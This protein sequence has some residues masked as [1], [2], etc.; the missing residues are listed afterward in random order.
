MDERLAGQ[1]MLALYRCGRQADA[2][3]HFQQMRS[4]MVDELGIDPGPALKR[5]HEQI[6]TTD[7]ELALP[8]AHQVCAGT[9]RTGG[10]CRGHLHPMPAVL[11]GGHCYTL[12]S[13]HNLAATLRELGQHEQAC[14]PRRSR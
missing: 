14:T 3:E 9:H 5:L 1:L 2:L 11:G 6:L 13:V 8:T 12:E 10:A 7:P 4:R